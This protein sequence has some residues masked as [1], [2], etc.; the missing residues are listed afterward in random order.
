MSGNKLL[1]SA[2]AAALLAGCASTGPLPVGEQKPSGP[3][4]AVV[5]EKRTF[6]LSKTPNQDLEAAL[7]DALSSSYQAAVKNLVG[8]KPMEVGFTYSMAPR[9]ASYPFSEIEVSCIMQEKYAR[10][11]GPR[12]CG[13]FFQELDAELKSALKRTGQ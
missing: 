1:L 13:D 11:K 3:G 9:G 12:L 2:C 10:R 8:E 5:F 7:G 6:K 4:A